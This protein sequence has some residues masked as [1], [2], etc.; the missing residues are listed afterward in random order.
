MNFALNFIN[1]A[2]S[3][4]IQKMKSIADNNIDLKNQSTKIVFKDSSPLDY[5]MQNHR[6]CQNAVLPEEISDEFDVINN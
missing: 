3:V 2:Y 5:S 6:N 1:P 4:N